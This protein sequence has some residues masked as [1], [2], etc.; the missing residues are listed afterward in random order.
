[1]MGFQ[2]IV[3]QAAAED[4][5]DILSLIKGL[6]VFEGEDPEEVVKITEKGTLFIYKL[7]FF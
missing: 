6:A 7:L 4:C 2:Y 1:M 5:Q 3:R